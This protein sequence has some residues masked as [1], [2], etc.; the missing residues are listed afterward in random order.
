MRTIIVQDCAD[1]VVDIPVADVAI[2]EYYAYE[3]SS[4]ANDIALI[5]LQHAAPYTDYIR[6]ICLPIG[7]LQNRTYIDI[8]MTA[9]GFGRTEKGTYS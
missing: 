5:R 9:A 3:S 8:P 1:P 2:H 6:P 4:Q 7:N